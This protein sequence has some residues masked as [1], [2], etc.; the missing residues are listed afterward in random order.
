MR[1]DD[2]L[3]PLGTPVFLSRTQEIL[4]WMRSLDRNALKRLWAC[5]DR[6]V[7]QNMERLEHMD[8]HKAV[9]PAVLSYDGIAYQYLTPEAFSDAEFSY[10]Q[11]HLRTLSGFYGVLKPM[12]GV[13]PYRLEMQAKASVHGS[14]DLY[15]YWKD[16]LYEEVK[17]DVILNLASKEYSKC[18]E[19]YLEPGIRF[20]TVVFGE[21]VNGKIVQ[22]GVY[23][24][25]ARGD[26]VSW[27][28]QNN[29]T[30]PSRIREYSRLGYHYAEELSSIDHPVFVKGCDN[31]ERL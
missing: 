7:D 15:D 14:L 29:I 19:E 9:T 20:I 18:V 2:D 1:V 24:K 26:M 23:A 16:S 5:S 4:D 11:E 27:L 8:L 25:M 17:E 3:A 30:D 6:I 22:K 21:V 28:A 13:V 31:K 10:V 12:D